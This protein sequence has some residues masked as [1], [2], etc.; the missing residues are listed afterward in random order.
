MQFQMCVDE[1]VINRLFT[2]I[3]VSR[4]VRRLSIL[5][6]HH[7]LGLRSVHGPAFSKLRN[8]CAHIP[9]P[10]ETITSK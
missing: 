7:D 2:S 3:H 1:V 9:A 10:S 4:H 8:K 6:F 5:Y